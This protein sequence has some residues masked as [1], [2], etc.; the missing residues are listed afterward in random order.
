MRGNKANLSYWNNKTGR[1]VGVGDTVT[2]TTSKFNLTDGKKYKVKEVYGESEVSV[3]NDVG[4]QEIY[5]VEWF[6]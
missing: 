4:V 1:L 5:T 2:A 3:F 6:K